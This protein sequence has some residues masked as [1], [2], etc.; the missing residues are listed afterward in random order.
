MERVS[1]TIEIFRKKLFFEGLDVP[2]GALNEYTNKEN[3]T[4]AWEHWG[5]VKEG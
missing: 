5:K 3:R 4:Q 1:I 2:S